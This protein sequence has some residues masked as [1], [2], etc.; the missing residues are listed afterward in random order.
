MKLCVPALLYFVMSIVHMYVEMYKENY[1]H[2]VMIG[3]GGVA[4]TACLQM[5][6]SHGF[7]VLSWLIVLVPTIVLLGFV[8]ILVY[9]FNINPITGQSTE[10]YE[11]S[12]LFHG[13]LGNSRFPVM[14]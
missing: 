10:P 3:V 1:T 6:C 11:N 2:A 7:S 12:K 8:G 4:V 5:L 13:A 14:T 9:K